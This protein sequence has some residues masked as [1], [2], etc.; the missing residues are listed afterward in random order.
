MTIGPVTTGRASDIVIPPQGLQMVSGVPAPTE[1]GDVTALFAAVVSLPN[2]G[3]TE[4]GVANA[5]LGDASPTHI[6]TPWQSG[7]Y[8]FNSRDLGLN[9]GGTT[10]QSTAEDLPYTIRV[11]AY[12][13]VCG[14]GNENGLG[15]EVVGHGFSPVDGDGPAAVSAAYLISRDVNIVGRT[16]QQNLDVARTEVNTP[17]ADPETIPNEV[18]AD[19]MMMISFTAFWGTFDGIPT[20]APWTLLHS[21]SI[22]VQTGLQTQTL[23]TA[24]FRYISNGA[25]LAPS[26][27]TNCVLTDDQWVT[28]GARLE[29]RE[30]VCAGPGGGTGTGTGTGTGSGSGE[31]CIVPAAP[32][33]FGGA[34][35]QWDQRRE[36][37]P[38]TT[39]GGEPPD[40]ETWFTWPPPEASELPQPPTP[41][42]KPENGQYRTDRNS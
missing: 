22:E 35:P 4:I 42:W 34:L 1:D 41:P 11:S 15:Y 19:P 20:A 37:D 3:P 33:A 2:L 7:R 16:G 5:V 26:P 32:L 27:I 29:Q 13:R 28:L 21:Q 12:Y 14:P 6:P 17:S 9:I 30:T 36:E 40:E 25:V 8:N 38:V 31:P 39:G 23:S 10:S 18:E 24:F